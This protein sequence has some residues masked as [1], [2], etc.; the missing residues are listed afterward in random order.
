MFVADRSR[1]E[2]V[3]RIFLCLCLGDVL[4]DVLVES[5]G[6]VQIYSFE[7]VE[8]DIIV[9]LDQLLLLF[10]TQNVECLLLRDQCVA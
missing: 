8:I 7:L 2:E 9:D 5:H 3:I 4:L 10:F 1:F 6:F